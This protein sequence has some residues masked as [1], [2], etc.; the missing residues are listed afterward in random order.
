MVYGMVTHNTYYFDKL[1]DAL[2]KISIGVPAP[3]K[4]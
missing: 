1:I 3:S 2:P 4:P